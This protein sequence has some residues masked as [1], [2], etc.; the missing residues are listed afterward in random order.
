MCLVLKRFEQWGHYCAW[1]SLDPALGWAPALAR[2][3][4]AEETG[5]S[6]PAICGRVYRTSLAMDL[7]VRRPARLKPELS[8]V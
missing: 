5:A 3:M 8:Q 1:A 6:F 7:P 2:Q 4:V